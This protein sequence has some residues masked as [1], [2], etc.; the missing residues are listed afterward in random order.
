MKD[1]GTPKVLEVKCPGEVTLF[2]KVSVPAEMGD[3]TVNPPKVGQYRNVLLTYEATGASYMFS[4]DGIPTRIIGEKGEKGD[5]GEMGPQGP[6]GEQGPAGPQGEQ[7]SQGPVGPQGPQGETGAPGAAATVT[8]GTTTTLAPGSSASVTNSGTSSA[9]IFDFAIPQGAKGD[10]GDKGDDGAGVEIAGSVATYANLP[11]TL[12]PDDA[13]KG[14]YVEADGKLY[15]WNGTSFPADGSGVQI[16]GPKGD[17]GDTGDTGPQG[18]RG[19][20]GAT[21]ATGPQG[22][23]GIQGEQGAQGIQGPTGPQGPTGAQG[24]QGNDGFSPV[25]TVTQ[26]QTGAT[27]TI[28][29]AQGTTTANITNGTDANV[30]IATTAVAGKVKPDGTT[31]TVAND[32][33]IT[34]TAAAL[35]SN[36]YT[37]Y[38]AAPSNVASSPRGV[39]LSTHNS[40]NGITI[41]GNGV[42]ATANSTGVAIG[43]GASATGTRS[44]AIGYASSAPYYGATCIN[45]SQTMGLNATAVGFGAIAN[46]PEC[47]AIGSQA[48]I[49][50]YGDLSVA[51]GANSRAEIP[52]GTLGLDG[53]P[54]ENSV[55]LGANSYADADYTVSVGLSTDMEDP[56]TGTIEIA[57]FTRRITNV[58]A[59]VGNNDAVT[60]GQLNAAISGVTLNTISDADWAALFGA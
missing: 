16:Q 3:E 21:G 48:W 25:A 60:V 10:K 30:P 12:G 40:S 2:H 4:S 13:G 29:D 17:K 36:G 57:A 33:T 5:Q 8:A 43:S 35:D 59:G 37:S 41:A 51:I 6:Q 15:I 45:G 39:Y 52:S 18:P 58:T 23:Q 22:P 42:A 11:T 26:T 19:E 7:G 1:C 49:Q 20:T 9:A 28:T 27:I 44:L 14:Y 55:A 54:T 31:I 56:G 50:D 46:A 53:T 38:A 47:V 34:A 24:P 32:G